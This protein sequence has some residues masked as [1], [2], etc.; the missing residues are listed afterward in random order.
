VLSSAKLHAPATC[1]AALSRFEARWRDSR[2]LVAAQDLRLVP[3]WVRKFFHPET[4]RNALAFR[5]ACVTMK[6][7]FL[8]ACLLGILHH[9]R[10][11]CLSFL[12]SHLVPY[13][14]DRLFPRSQHP[15]LYLE[16]DVAIRMRRKICRAYR[17]IPTPLSATDHR[18]H[19][20]DARSLPV[21]STIDLLLT[22]PPYMNELDYVRD[23]RLRLW[24]IGRALPSIPDTPKRERES[25]FAGL[26]H[27]VFARLVPRV[28]PGGHV[29]LILGEATRGRHHFDTANVAHHVLKQALK[30]ATLTLVETIHDR[31]PDVRRSRRGM[32]GTKLETILLYQRN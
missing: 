25:E 18:V 12:S 7:H 11:G 26:I 15:E 31:I 17:R 10:P 1:D 16:R 29:V 14:R 28:R 6:D 22:S 27:D 9:Q 32:Q 2:A 4:L 5:D 20:C 24:F 19:L 21:G 13:L 23:N 3:A 8:L 30:S